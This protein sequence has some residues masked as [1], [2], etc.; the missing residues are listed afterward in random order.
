M[1]AGEGIAA[2]TV[3]AVAGAGDEE[4]CEAHAAVS[5]AIAITAISRRRDVW[6][7]VG[8]DAVFGARAYTIANRSKT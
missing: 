3:V 2:L 5:V 1:V 6:I 8:F 7:M 4:G